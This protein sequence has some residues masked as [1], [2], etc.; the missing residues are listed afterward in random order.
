M[1]LL[2]IPSKYFNMNVLIIF[3]S[4]LFVFMTGGAMFDA[5][6]EC[7]DASGRTV[8][9]YVGLDPGSALGVFIITIFFLIDVF[10]VYLIVTNLRSGE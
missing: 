3:I 1:T 8:C 2:S 4:A 5:A 10:T 9:E 7:S 6:F